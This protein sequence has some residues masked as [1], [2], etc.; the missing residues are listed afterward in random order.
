MKLL[1]F[2]AVL[3]FRFVLCNKIKLIID[4]LEKSINDHK[5][6]KIMEEWITNRDYYF[7]FRK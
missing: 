3:F 4:F 2:I 7:Y 5:E 6:N 1:S